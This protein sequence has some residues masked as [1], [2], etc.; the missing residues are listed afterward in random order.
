MI[1]YICLTTIFISIIIILYSCPK[2]SNSAFLAS[3]F[4]VLSTYGFTHYFAISTK[5]ALG[6]AITYNHFSPLWVL[7]GPFL[8]FYVRGIVSDNY[9]WRKY[10]WIHFLPF[11]AFLI[12]VLPY[13]FIPFS[14]KLAIAYKIQADLGTLKNLFINLL[15]GPKFSF[16]FR[17]AHLLIYQIAS[18][19]FLYRYQNRILK[20]TVSEEQIKL[21]LRWL[22]VL[23]CVSLLLSIT[24]FSVIAPFIANTSNAERIL[25]HPFHLVSGIL[26]LLLSGSLLFFPQIL[27]GIPVYNQ[28]SPKQ[29][30]P[31]TTAVEASKQSDKIDPFVPLGKKILTYLEEEK[32]YLKVHFSVHDLAVAMDVPDHHI[33]YCF[34]KVLNM[35]FPALKNQLRVKYAQE[36]LMS[37]I[38]KEITMEALSKKAGFSTR[39]NFYAAFKTEVGISPSEFLEKM[40]QK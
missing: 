20:N 4:I 7:A 22:W 9:S 24:F 5:S 34:N 16:L 21:V 14:E 8:F 35:K 12:N 28:R 10:D 11:L 23:L 15:F 36:L 13:Y 39:S 30:E 37:G 27:Y 6:L 3:Y 19:V 40:L 29:K 33:T 32:P 1:L 38:A 31:D 25:H 2:N 17:S 18:I 26:F